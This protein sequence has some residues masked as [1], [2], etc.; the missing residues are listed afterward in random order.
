MQR[1]MRF[2]VGSLALLVLAGCGR[3]P[4]AAEPVEPGRAATAVDP[5]DEPGLLAR[6]EYLAVTSGCND[7]H[8]PG[9]AESGGRTPREQWLL[10]TPIG[11]NGPWGTTYAA[12]LRLKVQGMDEASWLDYTATLHTRP[13]MP[14]FG[15]RAMSEEDR[16][17][18]FRFI[19]SLGPGGEPAPAYLPPGRQPPLPFVRWHLPAPAAAAPAPG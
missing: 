10:G 19:R 18:L 15:V 17:A 4:E 12:N 6:G 13:P 3:A 5:L 11:W 2:A 9:Y 16:R 7:C 8:S 1:N 14:D